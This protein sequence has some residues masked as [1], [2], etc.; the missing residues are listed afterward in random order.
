MNG[1]VDVDP[2]GFAAA[3]SELERIAFGIETALRQLGPVTRVAAPGRD[4]VSIAT[5]TSATEVAT[6]FEDDAVSGLR[7]LRNIAAV[8][9]AQADGFDGADSTA[10]AGLRSRPN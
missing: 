5:A 1:N 3:A 2:A 6:Q 10:A 8:L 9:R 7:E 4:E